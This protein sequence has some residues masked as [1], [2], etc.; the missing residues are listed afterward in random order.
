MT[1]YLKVSSVEDEDE[2]VEVEV[3]VDV[4]EGEDDEEG[5]RVSG[6]VRRGGS[7]SS[8]HTS[9]L[10]SK[11]PSQP[12]DVTYSS[13]YFAVLIAMLCF[14][15]FKREVP[16]SDAIVSTKYA[17]N[18]ASHLMIAPIMGTF[19]GV[20]L[21]FFLFIDPMRS[22]LLA[23]STYMAL[24]TNLG[25]AGALMFSQYWVI[26]VL[27]LL[28]V[29]FFELNK[30]QYARSN[31]DSS[32]ALINMAVDINQSFHL[33]LVVASFLLI[34]AQTC[35]LLW[36]S[37]LLVSVVSKESI[38]GSILLA[39]LFFIFL[40][41]ICHFFRTLIGAVVGGSFLWVFMRDQRPPYH[42]RYVMRQVL[43]YVNT[44]T[45]ASIGSICKAAILV[46]PCQAIL[47]ATAH[48]EFRVR[49][50][51][52]H[53]SKCSGVL[54]HTL[55]HFLKT[56]LEPK[57]KYFPRLALFYVST[58]GHSLNKAAMVV[59]QKSS[60]GLQVLSLESTG[61]LFDNLT[62]VL[63]SGVSVI[64]LIV[65][66]FEDDDQSL[67]PFWPLFYALCFLL[68]Y[69]SVSVSVQGFCS[70]ADALILSFAEKPDLFEEKN[71]IL[72]HRWIRINEI[73][74]A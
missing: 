9:V 46:P 41:L 72:Y 6:A 51:S 14:T 61:S 19:C 57:A 32:M 24:L 56:Y 30:Y 27:L 60:S 44:C 67:G 48:L 53:Q 1:D 63:A 16:L 4:E 71:A 11:P 50:Y 25:L 29:Y 5:E 31:M 69:A 52:T 64:L 26:G 49:S 38:T 45:T 65:A 47:S 62:Y 12:R 54:I 18:W 8:N 40:Y 33:M 74:M 73:E 59:E 43:L 66:E 39:I 55:I 37:A 35:V 3:D 34:L 15:L 28:E 68:A 23:G 20:C 21:C 2:D 7:L 22:C 58:Y 42:F 10:I 17:G 70:A 13:I 36:W